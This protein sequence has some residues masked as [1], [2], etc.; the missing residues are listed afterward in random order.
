MRTIVAADTARFYFN[1]LAADAQ[2]SLLQDTLKTREESVS[3][4]TDRYQAGIIGDYRNRAQKLNEQQLTQGDL[5][6]TAK[7]NE[8][9]YMLYR[10][11][12]E[13]AR[14]S[15]ALDQHRILNVSIAQV[16]STPVLPRHSPTLIALGGMVVAVLM[17]VGIAL[18]SEWADKSFRTPDE[19]Q[20]YLEIPV[21][22]SLGLGEPDGAGGV[23]IRR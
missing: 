10:K 1:L 21:F 17:S 5:L 18:A 14:I 8:E 6:R 22:A 15:D 23:E 16:P 19:V 13:E 2:L 4:Q 9:N 7:I 12:E 3:L 11:T 20:W